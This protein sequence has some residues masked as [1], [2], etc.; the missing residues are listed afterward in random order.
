MTS[1]VTDVDRLSFALFMAVALHAVIVLGITFAP[2]SPRPSAQ[3][4]E[5]TLSQFDEEQA[6]D[7]ADFLAATNQ[8]G[9]GTLDE[10]AEM[11]TTQVA[12]TFQPEPQPVQPEPPSAVEPQPDQSPTVVQTQ[13]PARDQTPESRPVEPDQS[14]P[15]PKREKRSL[16]ERSL[17]IASLEARLDQQQQAYARKPRI[18]RLTSASTMAAAD[19]RWVLDFE[20]RIERIGTINYPGSE[21]R[22]L[23][24][25]ARSRVL[26]VVR[27]DGTL[28]QLE[29]L[30]SSGSTII[31]D[32]IISI[33]RMGAPYA[34]FT[35]EQSRQYDEIEIIRTFEFRDRRLSSN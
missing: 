8:Q 11:T 20:Q 34:P 13:A 22:R 6:P 33:V 12:E 25:S 21:V 23:G 35:G 31:D 28:K 24:H 1:Q 5:I 2:E 3:T 27:K 17:E 7:Q 30:D 16:L 15:L 18:L 29:I 19:A 9:S 10:M 14:E 4:M 32:A 26:V